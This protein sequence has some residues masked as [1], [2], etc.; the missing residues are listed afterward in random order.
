MECI[1]FYQRIRNVETDCSRAIMSLMEENNLTEIEIPHVTEENHGV[2]GDGTYIEDVVVPIISKHYG[3]TEV[4]VYKVAI[5]SINDKPILVI[6][7]DDDGDVYDIYETLLS[8]GQIVY[9]Y[10]AIYYE[11]KRMKEN[12]NE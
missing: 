4:K 7:I 6:T 10:Q 5:D 11:I 3:I 2:L 9:I 1:D 12:S 8:D